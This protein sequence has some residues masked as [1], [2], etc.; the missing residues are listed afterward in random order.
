MLRV[1]LGLLSISVVVLSCGESHAAQEQSRPPTSGTVTAARDKAGMK[2]AIDSAPVT[3]AEI[4]LGDSVFNGRGHGGMCSP[5]HGRN[6]AGTAA[7]PSL[8][9]TVWIHGDGSLGFIEGTIYKGVPNPTQHPLPMPPLGR[10]LTERQLHAV[11]AYVY[12][13]SHPQAKR[14]P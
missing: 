11:A 1:F 3:A 7:A 4:A 6:G 13:L 10:S 12:A 5:C 8:A 2:A 9:D 14:E